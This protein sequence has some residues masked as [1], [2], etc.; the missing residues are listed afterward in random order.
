MNKIEQE[1]NTF[2]IKFIICANNNIG[3][4]SLVFYISKFPIVLPP[5]YPEEWLKDSKPS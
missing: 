1:L 5:T 4:F 3:P 2:G